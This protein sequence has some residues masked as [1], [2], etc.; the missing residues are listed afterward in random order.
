[1]TESLCDLTQTQFNKLK[2]I[3]TNHRLM[4][5]VAYDKHGSEYWFVHKRYEEVHNKDKYKVAKVQEYKR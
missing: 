4:V 2:L 1:M 3:P 5:S